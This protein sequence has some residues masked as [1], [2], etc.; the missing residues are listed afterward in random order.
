MIVET[1]TKVSFVA[2]NFGDDRLIAFE[3]L[4]RSRDLGDLS[5]EVFR[6]FQ[7]ARMRLIQGSI[8]GL[9]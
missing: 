9:T 4:S 8:V 5:D 3:D 1:R 6:A 7:E 2:F